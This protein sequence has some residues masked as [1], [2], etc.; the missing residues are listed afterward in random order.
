LESHKTKQ[1]TNGYDLMAR[2]FHIN[3]G[4]KDNLIK[5][6]TPTKDALLLLIRIIPV[7][8]IINA[9]FKSIP[10]VFYTKTKTRQRSKKFGV[11]VIMRMK[12]RVRHVRQDIGGENG[13]KNTGATDNVFGTSHIKLVLIK[14]Q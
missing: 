10:F 2:K 3:H 8:M 5:M 7:G 12:I 11:G 13:K 1:Q 9:I 14:G 6:V 4:A